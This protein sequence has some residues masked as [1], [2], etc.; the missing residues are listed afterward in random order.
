MSTSVSSPSPRSPTRAVGWVSVWGVL[1]AM[2]LL[3]FGVWRVFPHA[4]EPMLTP[5][6]MTRTQAWLYA[7]CVVFNA[8][9]EG[10]KAFQKMVVPRALVRAH[11]L[12]EHPGRIPAWS[13]PF[14][15]AGFFAMKRRALIVRYVFLIVIIGVIVGMR[16]VPQPWR[17]IIDAGVVVGLGWGWIAMGVGLVQL[18]RGVV[19]DADPQIPERWEQH[20]EDQTSA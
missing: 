5:G 9:T 1:G 17:G 16:F 19:P 7:F 15:V 6:S 3:G 13:A 10:Y 4:L 18:I 20:D 2:A 12:N 8:W 11:W 14:F